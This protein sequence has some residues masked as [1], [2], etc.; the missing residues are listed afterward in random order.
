MNIAHEIILTRESWEDLNTRLSHYDSDNQ[1]KVNAFLSSIEQDIIVT[2]KADRILVETAN[3]DENAILAALLKGQITSSEQSSNDSKY[4]TTY[5]VQ[6][7]NF[8]AF[9]S[10]F[11][12]VGHIASE[13]FYLNQLLATSIEQEEY[14][15]TEIID[16]AKDAA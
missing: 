15:T 7:D 14:S 6:V 8:W 16:C 4:N 3:L 10:I 1:R 2:H 13:D 12:F 11:S 5:D 9:D